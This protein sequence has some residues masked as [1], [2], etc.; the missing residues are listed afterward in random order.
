METIKVTLFMCN[1]FT[2]TSL[3]SEIP[4]CVSITHLNMLF[5]ES[6]VQPVNVLQ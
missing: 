2:H 4:W 1:I 5:A 6:T 3:Q